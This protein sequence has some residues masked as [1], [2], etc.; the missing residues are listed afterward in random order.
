M[1]LINSFLRVSTIGIFILN[2]TF[3]MN[4]CSSLGILEE[5]KGNLVKAQSLFKKACN[6]G[7]IKGCF[8]LGVLEDKKGNTVKAQSL[9]KK[10]CD[11][12]NMKGCFKLGVLEDKKGNT[13]LKLKVFLKKPVMV[14]R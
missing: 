4:G 10:A 6:G 13:Q 3:V 1:N 11:G 12:G 14:E 7:N 9:F 5:E 2:I 8:K